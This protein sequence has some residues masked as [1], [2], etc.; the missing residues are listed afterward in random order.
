MIGIE[1]DKGIATEIETE[2]LVKEKIQIM[3]KKIRMRKKEET[4]KREIKEILI[5]KEVH[6]N[7]RNFD[8]DRESLTPIVSE[9][10]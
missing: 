9:I 3:I 6:Y 1:I 5:K 4:A 10:Q 8:K 2:T 7:R